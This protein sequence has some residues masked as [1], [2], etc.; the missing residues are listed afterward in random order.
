MRSAALVALL[1]LTAC[2]QS[3]PPAP[4]ATQ[5][6]TA[7]ASQVAEPVATGE[8]APKPSASQSSDSKD[9]EAAIGFSEKHFQALGTE[10][11]WSIEVMTGKLLYTSPDNQAGVAIASRLTSEGKRLRYSGTM[12]GKAL[13]LLIEPGTC[14]DGM[15][16]TVYAYKATFN[17]GG[18][19]EQGCAKLK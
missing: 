5:S 6:E 14:S 10:P 2:E 11:F 17:W 18:R 4:S 7:A 16:D 15:S 12:D 3:N 9:S 13:S 1:A 19:T 8:P